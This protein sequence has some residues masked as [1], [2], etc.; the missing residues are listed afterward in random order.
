MKRL[1][2]VVGNL[3]AVML[4][5]FSLQAL[6]ET[7][8]AGRDFNHDATGFP[9]TGVHTLT[10]CETCHVGGVFKG[11]P[12]NCDACHALGKRIVA[13]PKSTSHI[14]TDAPCETCHFNASTFLGA[15]FNHATAMRNQCVTCHNGRQSVGKPASHSS[16]H[17]ATDSCDNCHRSYTWFNATYNHV[18]VVP[19]TCDK[20]GCHVQGSNQYYRS[21][22]HVAVGLGFKCDACHNFIAWFP[23]NFKHQGVTPGT[24][25]TAGCH[26]QGGSIYY[27]EMATSPSHSYV[28]TNTKQCDVCHI[29]YTGWTVTVHEPQAGK[30]CSQCHNA[31][32]AEG[33]PSGHVSTSGEC[34][35]CHASTTTWF[36]AL[37]GMP[38]NH[39]PYNAG[40]Q[41]GTCHGG[42]T[43]TLVNKTTLHTW[44]LTYTCGVCHISPNKYTGNNQNTQK[45]HKTTG[46]ATA[47]SSVCTG[48]H[49]SKSASYSGW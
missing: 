44:S 9:L 12:R 41:C 3:L 11:T 29:S 14:V 48:C 37:G 13:T 2:K 40:V 47:A 38:S 33:K 42:A 18:G 8:L 36:G 31:S 23:A 22:T 28:D 43:S 35:T 49:G 32:A 17:M 6:A 30:T 34:N 45:A 25:K 7:P 24:C 39:I 16:G 19:G 15:R 21:S 5:V 20:A 1:G 10:A 46:T 27:A 4:T 26:V